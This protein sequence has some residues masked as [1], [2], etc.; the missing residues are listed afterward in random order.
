M[1][2]YGAAM[3]GVVYISSSR[4]NT[5][6]PSLTPN[7]HPRLSHDRNRM[8][9]CAWPALPREI[10]LNYFTNLITTR[11]AANQQHKKT[12]RT[13]SRT[14]FILG[15][16]HS[17]P[18][19]LRAPDDSAPGT[20]ELS[21]SKHVFTLLGLELDEKKSPPSAHSTLSRTMMSTRTWHIRL[22]RRGD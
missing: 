5:K 15:G 21:H 8:R 6:N 14:H 19:L 1:H 22:S 17:S 2:V 11:C 13:R 12:E 18:A 3:E 9:L 10:H 4:T 7:H 20:C 16:N